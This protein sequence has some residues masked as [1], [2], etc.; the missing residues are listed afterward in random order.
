MADFSRSILSMQ[1]IGRRVRPFG[2]FSLLAALLLSSTPSL[3]TSEDTG[4]WTTTT[5]TLSPSDLWRV[6]MT[7]QTR[8]LNDFGDL[9]RTVLRPAISYKIAKKTWVTAGYD[10]HFIELPT[11][12]LEQR[13]WQQWL[14]IVPL[15][16]VSLSARVRLEERFI[17]DIDGTAVRLRLNGRADFPIEGSKWKLTLSNEYFIGLND[18]NPGPN[19][20][21]DQNRAYVGVSRPLS[22]TLSLRLGYQNQYIN[23]SGGSEDLM[24]HQL[25]IGVSVKP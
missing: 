16:F 8:S 25:M 6:G 12:R 21:F 18:L 9:E 7:V 22:E 1:N 15:Q 2:F 11:D 20:G 5:G 17:E 3:A 10:A 4:F 23:R 24:V 13:A 19:D 14:T